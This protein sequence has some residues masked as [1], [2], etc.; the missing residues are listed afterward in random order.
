M[1]KKYYFFKAFSLINTQKSKGVTNQ[2]IKNE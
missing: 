2:I 1:V